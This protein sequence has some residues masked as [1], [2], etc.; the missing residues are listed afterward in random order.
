MQQHRGADADR[1]ALYGGDERTGGLAEIAD[2]S[3]CL[4][5]A[6]ILA[7]R[8]GAEIGEVVSGR[9]TVAISL[10]YYHSHGRI[11]LRTLQSIRHGAIH[12]VTQR[13]LLVRT[14]QRQRHDACDYFGFHMFSHDR[15]S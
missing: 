13:V 9:K 14:G 3:M 8:L 11:L 12:G 1:V 10:E 4:A 6:G 5:L 7:V 2:E 15:S